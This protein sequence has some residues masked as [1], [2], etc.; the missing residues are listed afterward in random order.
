MSLFANPLTMHFSSAENATEHTKPECP[1][2]AHTCSPTLISDHF[3]HK[4]RSHPPHNTTIASKPSSHPTKASH[5]ATSQGVSSLSSDPLTISVPSGEK[6]TKI[7]ELEYPDS[8]Q[9]P[10]LRL[11][12]PR[13]QL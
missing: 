11:A 3:H 5:L 13:N 4:T 6:A 8:V 10:G 9:I 2:D 1:I 7:T 12:N